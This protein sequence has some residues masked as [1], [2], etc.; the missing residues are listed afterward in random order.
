VTE[1]AR[2]HPET[3][4]LDY[5]WLICEPDP[6]GPERSA[7]VTEVHRLIDKAIG[8][9]GLLVLAERYLLDD[10]HQLAAKQLKA[11][12][13]AISGA[14]DWRHFA[15]RHVPH[16]ELRR[17]REE[18]G[19]LYQPYAGGPVEWGTSSQETAA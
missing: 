6:I 14:I 13:L 2:D 15:N 19:P 8:L 9:A 10:P 4:P 7:L 1:P 11:V 5:D 18:L 16:T 3:H 12:S 17:R